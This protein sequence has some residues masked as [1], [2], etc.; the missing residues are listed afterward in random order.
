MQKKIAIIINTLAT[1]GAEKTAGLLMHQLYPDMEIHLLMFNTTNIEFDIPSGVKVFQ[2]GKPTSAEASPVQVLKLP[3]QALQIKRYLRK[4]NIPLVFSILNRPNFIAGYLKLFGYRGKT[5]I[6]ERSNAS[7]YYTNKT[8]GGMLGRFLVRRLYRRADCIITNS[9]F[10][11][12]DLEQTFGLKNTIITISNGINYRAM[13]QGLRTVQFPFEKKEG[14][15]IFCHVGRYH[16]DKNQEMLLR[17]FAQLSNDNCRLVMAGKNIPQQLT[18]LVNELGL[19]GKVNLFDLQSDILPYY[20]VSDAFVLCSNVEGYPNV[21]I[22]AMACGLPVIAT[23]CKWGPREILA[24]D[25]DYPENILDKPEFAKNGILINCSDIDMLSASMNTL[26]SD[27]QKYGRYTDQ[28]QVAITAFDEETAMK[29]FKMVI[30][31]TLNQY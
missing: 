5:I 23:D 22:E 11:K 25:T 19:A 18:A 24:P 6:N 27:K 12:K 26:M 20:A 9:I 16:P 13:Q 15:F 17:A 30:F 28:L 2:I 3:L 31:D 8:L 4:H 10:S 1:G 14:E 21:I 29:A 7:Y